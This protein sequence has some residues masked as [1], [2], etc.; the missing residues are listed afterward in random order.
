M[1]ILTSNLMIKVLLGMAIVVG[2]VAVNQQHSDTKPCSRISYYPNRSEV[3][4][5]PAGLS[6][7]SLR[8]PYPIP[9]FTTVTTTVRAEG[10]LTKV[11]DVET[12]KTIR[13]RLGAPVV[14]GPGAFMAVAD[15]SG[16]VY[17]QAPSKYLLTVVWD[18][19]TTG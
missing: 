4:E 9:I 8:N 7:A 5:C 1:N 13:K 19:K 10:W 11:G 3:F 12:V 16:L 14:I 2:V 6:V 18:V 17:I 15:G